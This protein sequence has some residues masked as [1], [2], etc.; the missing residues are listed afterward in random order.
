MSK[1]KLLKEC[2][3]EITVEATKAKCPHAEAITHLNSKAQ[4]DHIDGAKILAKIKQEMSHIP[5]DHIAKI[6]EH[7]S[8]ECSAYFSSILGH[9]E[10]PMEDSQ[11]GM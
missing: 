10:Q 7:I 1:P 8:N 5:Q 11:D 9:T 3:A 2:M 4:Q 6:E